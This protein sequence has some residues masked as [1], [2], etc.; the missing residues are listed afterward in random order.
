MRSLIISAV[1]LLLILGIWFGFMTYCED[2]L[3][4]LVA[5]ITDE[6]EVNVAAED[7]DSAKSSFD[8]FSDAWHKDKSTYSFFLEQSAMLEADFAIARAE[9]CIYAED[10]PGAMSE[11]AFIREQL[12]FLFLNERINLAN[13][14]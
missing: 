6:I 13:I 8:E 11:L 9:A 7:W 2:T 12:K 10:V 14:L 3:T 1:S 5:D 4:S